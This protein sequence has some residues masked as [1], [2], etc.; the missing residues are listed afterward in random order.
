MIGLPAIVPAIAVGLAT[1]WRVGI[2]ALACLV[3]VA[4]ARDRLDSFSSPLKLWDDAVSKN[5][6]PRAPYV[7]RAYLAR[8]YIHF[9]AG[10][11]EVAGADFDRALE[12]NPRSPDAYVARGSLRLARAR[13]KEAL[14]D[15]DQA[16]ALDPGFASAYDKRCAV[17]M[18]L[19]RPQ[20]AAADC[21]KAVALDPKNHE[22]WINRGVLYHRWLARPV[23]ARTSYERALALE[24]GNGVANFNYGMLLVESGRRDEAV[25]RHIVIGCEAGIAS[26]CDILRRSRH[27][28]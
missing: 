5:T 1:R 11:L 9:D 22:A 16:I 15:M 4:G 28:P 7:E 14:E 27:A 18:G 3:L 17:K 6:D 25:R 10:R 20:D 24:P 19:K 13:L 26:A 8:G 23:E 2:V 21:D 12:L